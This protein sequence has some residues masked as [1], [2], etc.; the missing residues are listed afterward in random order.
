VIAAASAALVAAL[1]AGA[2]H[3]RR[4][5]EWSHGGD[6]VK[7]TVETELATEATFPDVTSRLGVP[8]GEATAVLAAGQSVVVRVTWSGATNGGRFQL[9]AL[10]GRVTPPR[11]LAADSGQV[12]DGT[13][14]SNWA[15]AYDVL[16]D[17]YD[18][19]ADVAPENH[20][21]TYG[22][23]SMPT[24]AVGAPAT[25]TGTATAWFHQPGDNPL[26]FR[27]PTQVVI[28]LIKVDKSGDV[29]WAKRVAGQ[30]PAS[31]KK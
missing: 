29:R 26:P 4:D 13:T 16:P 7:V 14:G 6:K 5:H 9:V 22:M 28:A 25:P 30:P 21:D 1:A 17:H 3:V 15:S 10:D 8:A 19:L 2:V 18:W 31:S 27:D 12:S 20:T 23:N 24:A 11:V